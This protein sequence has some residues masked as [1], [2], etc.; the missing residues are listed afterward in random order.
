VAKIKVLLVDDEVS[1]IEL[2]K[3]RLQARNYDVRTASNGREALKRI[4]QDR[5]DIVFLDISMPKMNGLE[6]LRRLR[7][8]YPDMPIYMLTALS[9]KS[10]KAEADKLKATGY[11]I[12]SGDLKREVNKALR[13]LETKK[14][15][16]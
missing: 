10:S 12:K 6:A 8:E 9:S 5:P 14:Q 13:E 11:I 2:I 7:K 3:V 16:F 1:F 15:L 4:N